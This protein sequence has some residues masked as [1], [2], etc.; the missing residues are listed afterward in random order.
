MLAILARYIIA[1]ELGIDVVGARDPVAHSKNC[2]RHRYQ[3]LL[4]IEGQQGS[5]ALIDACDYDRYLLAGVIG[6]VDRLEAECFHNLLAEGE[7]PAGDPRVVVTSS[8]T[9]AASDLSAPAR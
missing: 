3:A 6:E 2:P 8:R 1:Q 9:V 7:G 4:E 5:E